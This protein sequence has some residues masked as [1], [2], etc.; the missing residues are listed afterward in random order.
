MKFLHKS[1]SNLPITIVI[2][3]LICALFFTKSEFYYDNFELLDKIDT[4]VVYFSLMHFMFFFGKYSTDKKIFAS[5][6]ILS[7]ILRFVSDFLNEEIYYFLYYS[8]V[9]MPL[10]VCAWR[11]K[12][13]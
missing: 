3:W 1:I 12:K 4:Y 11:A 13:Y 2:Q 7:V 6:V 9:L 10:I 5:A 8:I